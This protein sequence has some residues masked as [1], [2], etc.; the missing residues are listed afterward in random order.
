MI[1]EKV[2]EKQEYELVNN[3]EYGL[4][5]NIAASQKIQT[6]KGRPTISTN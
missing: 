1:I 6:R 3:A 2:K 5:N 4:L